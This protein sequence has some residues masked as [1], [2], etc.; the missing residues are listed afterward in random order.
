MGKRKA[1]AVKTFHQLGKNAELA[2]PA[3]YMDFKGLI[4][5]KD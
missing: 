1:V 5:N 2:L 4:L 3:A